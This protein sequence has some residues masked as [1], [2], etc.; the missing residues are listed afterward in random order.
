[1]IETFMASLSPMLIL[2]I[3]VLVGYLLRKFSVVPQNTDTVISRLETFAI[4][5]ALTFSSF[6]TYCTMD[7]L[8]E[9]W[10]LFLYGGIA[11]AFS[12]GL[13]YLLVHFF[14]IKNDYT[15]CC[16]KYALT[17]SNFGYIGNAVVP[18]L[19]GGDEHL[20]MY[21]LFTICPSFVVY[22]WG[23]PILTPK[24]SRPKNPIMQIFTVPMIAIF[25]GVLFGL[26]GLGQKLPGF[27]VG[28]IDSL[29]ACMG[30]LAMV[31]TGFVI[32]GYNLKELVSDPKVYAVSLLRL[33]L[34]PSLIVAFLY[35]CGASTYVITLAFFAFGTPL[36]LNTVVFP[37]AFGGETKTGASM[38]MISMVLGVFTL[39]VMFALLQAVLAIL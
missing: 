5:P 20:Y 18:M 39:P 24:E 22:L 21:L 25:V 11:I 31:L 26:T 35:I 37:A 33:T 34:L 17:F 28:A 36:G 6:S 30:P 12:V 19:L 32:G 16:Y 13:A 15:K 38:A 27:M 8:R 2:F 29:K 3:C 1:M 7:S 10:S 9:N 23:F 4:V 14:P